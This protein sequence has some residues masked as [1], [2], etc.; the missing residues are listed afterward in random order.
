MSPAPQ[1]GPG[2]FYAI[3]ME[4]LSNGPTSCRQIAEECFATGSYTRGDD[5]DSIITCL[6]TRVH[7]MLEQLNCVKVPATSAQVEALKTVSDAGDI[8]ALDFVDNGYAIY[9]S[10][11]WRLPTALEKS[12]AESEVARLRSKTSKERRPK[13]RRVERP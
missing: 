6:T 9:D 1:P 2:S 10:I 5:R 3:V 13:K 7:E 11:P 8:S 4:R 12:A